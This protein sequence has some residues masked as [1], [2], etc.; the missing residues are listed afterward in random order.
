MRC[1]SM[2]IIAS[3]SLLDNSNCS[4]IMDEQFRTQLFYML[5]AHLLMLFGLSDTPVANNAPPG[6]LSSATEGTVSSTFEYKIPD[7]SM[8]APWYLQTKYGAL[9]W[10]ATARFRSARY[11]ASGN[12]G[13]GYARDFNAPPVPPRLGDC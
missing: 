9:F 11:M 5:V 2:F 6:R 7:G 13:I 8:I 3:N 1:N 10:T 12:S 4:P